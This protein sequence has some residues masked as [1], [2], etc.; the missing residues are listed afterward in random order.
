MQVREEA[1]KQSYFSGVIFCLLIH[2]GA[3]SDHFSGLREDGELTLQ[4]R[5]F[6]NE[7]CIAVHKAREA[8]DN[9]MFR[10]ALKVSAYDLGGA[11]DVY[12]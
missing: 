1:R 9:M 2:S 6:A 3:P 8:Y 10:E 4:D 5:V 7:I 12:R 11:R